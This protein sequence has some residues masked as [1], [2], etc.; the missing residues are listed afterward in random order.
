MAEILYYAAMP[1]ELIPTRA[2]LLNRL[3]DLQDQASWQDFYNIYSRLIFDIS[4]KAGLTRTEAQDV[5]QETIVSVARH[6]PTFKY[7]PSL[8][9][10][11]NWLLTMTRWRITDQL[12]KRGPVMVHDSET[13]TGTRTIERIP[14]PTVD[15]SAD[16]WDAEWKRSLIAAAEGNVKRRIDPLKYQIYDLYVHKGWAPEK[17]A[18]TF[19]IQKNNVYVNKTR[20]DAMIRDEVGRLGKEML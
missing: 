11:K 2:S 18:A 17:V 20:I 12:R 19:N 9:S 10:F 8:G 14:D 1:D 16:T 3:K 5:V 15:I 7:D 4:L 13:Q 6:I